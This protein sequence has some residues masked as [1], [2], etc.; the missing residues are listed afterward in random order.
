MIDFCR[1]QLKYL[2]SS[3]DSDS[4]ETSEILRQLKNNRSSLTSSYLSKSN[5]IESEELKKIKEIIERKM[6]RRNERYK[7]RLS[8]IKKSEG[9]HFGVKSLF[10]AANLAILLMGVIL[11]GIS[12]EDSIIGIKR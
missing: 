9:S 3:D 11:R 5:T 4:D 7:K 1:N 2:N 6:E 12:D 8:Q 10:I